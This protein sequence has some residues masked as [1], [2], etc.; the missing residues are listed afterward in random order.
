MTALKKYTR[1]E[2]PG[3]WLESMDAEPLEV[4]VSLGKSSLIIYDYEDNPLTHW[5][6]STLKLIS[7]NAEMIVF[8]TTLEGL[9]KLKIEDVYM[10]D[11]L[12]HFINEPTQEKSNKRLIRNVTTLILFFLLCSLLIIIPPKLSDLVKTVISEHHEAQI[13][14][15]HFKNHL[16]KNGQICSSP[17]TKEVITRILKKIGDTEGRLNIE[18]IK[19]QNAD[20]IHFP[21]GNLLISIALLQSIDNIASFTNLLQTELVKAKKRI[22]LATLIDQQSSYNLLK[23][24]LGMES[25]FLVHDVSEFTVRRQTISYNE[26]IELDDF[27]WVAL[28]NACLN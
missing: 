21:G 14:D 11:A 20:A 25:E 19:N 28:Q 27:S 16:R 23:F 18:I 24:I 5:S 13:I 2:A 10:K 8:S 9:E 22:P 1:L 17:L 7:Q 4:L 6:L 3:I 12:L 15:S 26:N